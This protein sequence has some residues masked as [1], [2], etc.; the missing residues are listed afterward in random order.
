MILSVISDTHLTNKF[1][2]NK[3]NKLRSIIESS[4]KIVLNGDFWDGYAT[5]F[6]DFYN[7]KWSALFPLLKSKKTIYLF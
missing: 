1:N 2:E 7:S 6:E 4:D 5:D 3:F